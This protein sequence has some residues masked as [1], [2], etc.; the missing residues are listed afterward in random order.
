[1]SVMSYLDALAEGLR[2]EMLRDP[3]VVAFGE[4]S[5]GGTGC[6]GSPGGAWGP[7]R[8][9]SEV[10]PGQIWDAPITEAAFVGAAVGAAA[11]G[12]RPVV[13]LLFVDFVGVC[14]DQILNQASKLRF[15]S[16]GKASVPLVIRA[17]TGA[18]MRRGAQHS[19]VLAPLFAHQ[20]GLKVL[21]PATPADAKGLIAAAIRDD[22]PVVLLESKML[23]FT[24]G[25]VPDGEH[26][27]PIGTAR[28]ARA[29]SDVTIVALGACVPTALAAAETLAEAGIEAE[30]VDP[31]TLAPLDTAAIV[32]SVDRTGGLVVVDES[33]PV[34]S[35][36]SEIAAT[37]AEHSTG[38]RRPVRRVTA[39]AA[40][41]P[42]SPPLE[43]AWIP[44][45]AQVV[46]AATQVVG[47]RPFAGVPR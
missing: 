44:G 20:P 27:V 42:F 24:Q 4:D 2:T 41:T 5:I 7:T 31:R 9:L 36:A 10:V 6:A 37:V 16:G 21:A 13:D 30:V 26:L 1:M 19:A 14:F 40:P 11:T 18:G 34:C 32:A 25:E 17:L 29:G 47:A 45:P 22:D 15:M 8:G 35:L 46:A 38:L 28:I 23:Y 3:R 39:P 12:L 43:D 33:Y